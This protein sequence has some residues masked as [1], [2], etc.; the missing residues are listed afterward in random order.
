MKFSKW[1]EN[2]LIKEMMG[3]VS[4]IVSCRD[5]KNP[6][7]QVQGALSNLKCKKKKK[8]KRIADFVNIK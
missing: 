4:S 3:S 7:F 2:K 8:K 6:N 1:L 5:L